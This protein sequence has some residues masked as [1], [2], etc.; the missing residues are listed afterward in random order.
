MACVLDAAEGDY[1]I[2]HAGVA[3]SRINEADAHQVLHE[4]RNLMEAEMAA[5][6]PESS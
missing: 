2:V 6:E 1:V 3:I 5:E 4:I